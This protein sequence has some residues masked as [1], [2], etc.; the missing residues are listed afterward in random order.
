LKEAES[1]LLK[2]ARFPAIFVLI[3]WVIKIVDVF[4]GLDFR[5]WGVYP[6]DLTGLRGII[7][8]P[9][10]HGDAR[11]EGF[12]LFGHFDHVFSN[13]IPLLV[14]GF[15]L[16]YSYRKVAYKVWAAIWVI[17][18]AAVWMFARGSIH[19][20]A[21][22]LVYGLAFFVFFSGVFRKDMKSIAL[23][24]LVAFFYGGLVWG[25]LPLQSGVSWEGHLFGAFAGT[26]MAWWYQDVG[27]EK[28]TYA[29]MSEKEENPREVVEKP[30]WVKEELE[31]PPAVQEKIDAD[32]ALRALKVKYHIKKNPPKSE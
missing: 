28:K 13:S 7:F 3:I 30:F 20:G 6:R 19:I 18:G 1:L 15:I 26:M 24:L 2:A 22:G 21:S 8:Y 12:Q 4:L 5:S 11:E 17:S 31:V 14:L 27:V 10:L 9:L 29:W 25:V 23:A 32:A 16:F